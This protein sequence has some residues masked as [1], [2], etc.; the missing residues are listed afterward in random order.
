MGLD[1]GM[2]KMEAGRDLDKLIA[3]KVMGLDVKLEG[4]YEVGP[5][6]KTE[7]NEKGFTGEESVPNYSTDL[8]A[9]MELVDF[10]HEKNLGLIEFKS[11]RP[12]NHPTLVEWDCFIYSPDGKNT[13][14]KSEFQP[15]VMVAVCK[16]II[17]AIGVEV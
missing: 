14:G 16:A 3:E 1:E 13:I 4:S 5:V 9:T 10:F 8:E 6:Y 2:E 12:I 17:K 11:V 7:P 15:T